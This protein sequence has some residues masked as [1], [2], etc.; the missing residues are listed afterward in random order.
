MKTNQIMHRPF[1]NFTVRQMHKTGFLNC[2]DALAAVNEVRLAK[3]LSE[4][5]LY[6]FFQTDHSE[7]LIALCKYLNSNKNLINEFSRE[8]EPADLI[9]VKKG[10]TGGTWLYPYYFTKFARWLS[11]EFEAMVDIWVSDNLLFYRDTGGEAYKEMCHVLDMKFNIGD[12]GWEYAKVARRIAYKVFGTEDPNQWNFG[13]QESQY[14]RETL[15]RRV[16]S[17]VEF[18]N[19]RTID[20]VINVI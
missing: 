15:Q 11:P 19:F 6:D 20:D 16:I 5:R 1:L 8:L 18:G 7:Y 3:G 17:A 13:N 10:K 12:K 14:K 4:K 2:N 9:I